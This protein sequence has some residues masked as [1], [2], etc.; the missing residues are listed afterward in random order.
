MSHDAMNL[1]DADDTRMIDLPG[2][3]PCPRPVDIDQRVTG[4]KRLKSLRIYRFVPGPAIHGDSETDEVFILPLSGAFDMQ[5]TGAHP[6]TARVSAF[7]P[8]RALYMPPG[9][10]YLLTPRSTVT[11]AYA[12][13]EAKGRVATQPVAETD[14][15]GLAEH[16]RYRLVQAKAGQHLVPG[17]GGETFGHVVEG[18]LN[19]AEGRI[20]QGQTLALVKAEA[21]PLQAHTDTSLLII[22]V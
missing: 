12:R 8:T 10:S 19:W 9:H 7:G 3:G 1:I 5:I 21:A 22:G 15:G 13:A 14:C 6:L 16:L 2:V 20:D 4:F 11:V 18:A 17:W